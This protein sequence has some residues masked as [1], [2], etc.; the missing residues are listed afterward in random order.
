M[1]ERE[2][3]ADIDIDFV[4]SRE[5]DYRTKFEQLVGIVECMYPYFLAKIIYLLGR[6]IAVPIK[7][8]KLLASAL[9]A[10][11]NGNGEQV[12]SLNRALSSGQGWDAP[13]SQSLANFHMNNNVEPSRPPGTIG[14]ERRQTRGSVA[15]NLGS[16]MDPMFNPQPIVPSS[17]NPMSVSNEV[18]NMV[19]FKSDLMAVLI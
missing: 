19:S 10:T 1:P 3:T 5:Q 15:S 16:L 13:L 9:N 11:S 6:V 2:L 17:P 4:T 12:Y 7:D 14:M 8:E 18:F